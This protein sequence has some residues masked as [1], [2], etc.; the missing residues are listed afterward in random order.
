M[1]YPWYY[2]TQAPPSFHFGHASPRLK[3]SDIRSDGRRLGGV[4]VILRQRQPFRRTN[5]YHWLKTKEDYCR[6]RRHT[7]FFQVFLRNGVLPPRAAFPWRWFTRKKKYF[8][9]TISSELFSPYSLQSYDCT[10]R[11][12]TLAVLP[13]AHQ[14]QLSNL[15][16]R[17]EFY[18]IIPCVVCRVPSQN[19]FQFI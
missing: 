7:F 11:K 6:C 16:F 5:E 4:V 17:E 1:C 2:S 18:A 9:H 3:R 8:F 15:P 13:S 10:K 19:S 12:E 14:T